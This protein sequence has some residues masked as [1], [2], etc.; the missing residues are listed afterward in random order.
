MSN[1]TTQSYTGTSMAPN[2]LLQ[3]AMSTT[4]N[5]RNYV[6]VII[7]RTRNS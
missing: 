2:E 4:T 3:T 7:I 6:C 1:N 5:T